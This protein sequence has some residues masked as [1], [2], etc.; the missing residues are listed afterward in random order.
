[1]IGGGGE[2]T[3]MPGVVSVS[4][5]KSSEASAGGFRVVSLGLDERRISFSNWGTHGASE[6]SRAGLWR[7]TALGETVELRFP[8]APEAWSSTCEWGPSWC[9][10]SQG[11]V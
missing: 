9:G 4:V 11:T 2:L 7:C 3:I 10:T 5:E 8:D 1:V 6:V